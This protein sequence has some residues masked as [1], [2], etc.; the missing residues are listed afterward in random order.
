MRIGMFL[1]LIVV[2]EV[3]AKLAIV[4]CCP[5]AVGTVGRGFLPAALLAA[6]L[7]SSA[8]RT[9]ANGGA[10]CWAISPA[11]CGTAVVVAFDPGEAKRILATA[12]ALA[13]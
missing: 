2:V 9:F 12:P 13:R 5:I 4:S 10:G 3:V 8:R 7:T 11:D 1:C 6:L